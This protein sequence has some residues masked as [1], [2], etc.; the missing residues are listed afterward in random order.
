MISFNR[1]G[2][3]GRLG[4]QLFQ[5]AFLR[6]TA[7]R[8][9][10]KFYCP[11]WI[12]DEVFELND[13]DERTLEPIDIHQIYNQPSHSSGFNQD[14][15]SI[16]DGTDITG[17]F[18]TERYWDR[19]L[20]REWYRFR[21]NKICRVRRKYEQI[22]FAKSVAIHL[23][24]GDFASLALNRI[25]FYIPPLEYYIR[26]FSRIEKSENIVVFSDDIQLARQYVQ[27]WNAKFLFIDNNE[28]YE[29]VYLMSRCRDIIIST[30]TLSWWGAFLGESRD[31]IVIAPAEGP[32]RPGP[33][34]FAPFYPLLKISNH[35]YLCND[36]IKVKSLRPCVDNRLI[37]LMKEFFKHPCAMTF[38]FL[39]KIS[40]KS[41]GK[42]VK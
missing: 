16:K 14:A 33:L 39:R 38:A 29:D 2:N 17:Y 21:E 18:Q 7:R 32:F 4:N 40:R 41:R 36:W 8:L 34:F 42:T 37:V 15:L 25:V 11:H 27:P 20:V 26:A 28:V 31:R 6:S 10:V 23:R 24:F 19:D 13:S 9:G 35:D 22:D 3:Y 30:S 12:G 1:L 5:Y